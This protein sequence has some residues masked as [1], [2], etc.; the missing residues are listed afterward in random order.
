[1]VANER[2]IWVNAKGTARPP[3][4]PKSST[5]E[6]SIGRL[7]A[8]GRTGTCGRIDDAELDFLGLC[9]GGVGDRSGFAPRH[10]FLIVSLQDRIVAVEILCLHQHARCRGGDFLDPLLIG[11]SLVEAPLHGG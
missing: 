2:S 8:A 4:I 9:I 5:M 3:P 1:M 10:Q 7:G 11:L 6:T